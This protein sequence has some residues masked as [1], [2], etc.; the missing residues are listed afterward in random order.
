MNHI[1]Y[2][3]QPIVYSLASNGKSN[4]SIFYAHNWS[5]FQDE[6]EVIWH[7]IHENRDSKNV[8]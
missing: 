6:S 2:I 3:A 7:P 1:T 5:N 4:I 8:F